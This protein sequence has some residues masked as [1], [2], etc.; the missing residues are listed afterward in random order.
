LLS[1]QHKQTNNKRRKLLFV[2]CCE[3]FVSELDKMMFAKRLVQLSSTGSGALRLRH[4]TQSCCR[5]STGLGATG[6]TE[7][8]GEETNSHNSHNHHSN[9]SGWDEE[10]EAEREAV[11]AIQE[12]QN[13]TYDLNT[14]G[15]ME[16]DLFVKFVE[17]SGPYVR[18]VLAPRV[19]QLSRTSMVLSVPY[20]DILVGNFSAPCLNSG[21][22]SS[23]ID[24][25]GLY[26]AWASLVDPH[27]RVRTADLRVDY[28]AMMPL[29]A[30]KVSSKVVHRTK[31]LI[32]V[33]IQ[34]WN[35]TFTRKFALG[36]GTFLISHSLVDLQAALQAK[37]EKLESSPTWFIKQEAAKN[38]RLT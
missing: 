3:D 4:Q 25:A 1:T 2:A 17:Q 31:E 9:S 12:L 36:R 6:G 29:E 32:R 27:S 34:V 23:I 7:V 33:D 22:V 11:E 18:K 15:G 26:C 8:V 13:N 37:R 20:H 28:L 14:F 35:A 21:V 38:G 10:R 19:E 16:R 24:H 30:F 5:F